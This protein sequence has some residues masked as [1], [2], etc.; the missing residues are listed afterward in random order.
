MSKWIPVSERLPVENEAYLATVVRFDDNYIYV[1]EL[2]YEKETK[3]WLWSDDPVKYLDYKAHR[4]M[5]WQPLPE[6][7]KEASKD[8]K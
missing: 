3:N 8:A 4:V 7:Y 5:A 1:N 6:P 2:V